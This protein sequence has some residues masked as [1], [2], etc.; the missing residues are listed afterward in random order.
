MSEAKKVLIYGSTGYL[1]R[2]CTKIFMNNGWNDP[3]ASQSIVVPNMLPLVFRRA[4]LWPLISY[5]IKAKS[6]DAMLCLGGFRGYNK[7]A[8]KKPSNG[9]IVTDSDG[10]FCNVF[11][12]RLFENDFSPESFQSEDLGYGISKSL[13]QFIGWY[14]PE[15]ADILFFTP[16]FTFMMRNILDIEENRELLSNHSLSS[17]VNV[18]DFAKSDNTL[19]KDVV[20][21]FF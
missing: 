10:L 3:Q 7:S 12:Q 17:W 19:I 4:L 11:S 8:S 1:G 6:I 15:S 16:Y 5:K 2:A 21:C 18:D 9:K 13:Y 14:L 20:P